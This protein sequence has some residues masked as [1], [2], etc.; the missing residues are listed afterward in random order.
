MGRGSFLQGYQDTVLAG[1][2]REFE[3][4]LSSVLMFICTLLDVILCV[5]IPVYPAIF[6]VHVYADLCKYSS[7]DTGLETLVSN[8]APN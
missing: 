1:L 2:L 3:R 8:I 5:Y 4:Y 6:N 7:R